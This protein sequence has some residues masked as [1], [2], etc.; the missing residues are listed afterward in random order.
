MISMW[1]ILNRMSM[2]MY[3]GYGIHNVFVCRRGKM[4]RMYF[5]FL[6]YLIFRIIKE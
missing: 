2:Y 1:Y 4:A 3:Y 5:L 6:Y